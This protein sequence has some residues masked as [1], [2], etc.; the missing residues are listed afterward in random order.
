MGGVLISTPPHGVQ[1]R[2]M[3]IISNVHISE[4]WLTHIVSG[5]KTHE[6]RVFRGHWASLKVGDIL[7]AHS[8]K[9]SRVEL[10][11][12]ELL[13]FE[14][15]DSAFSQLGKFLL[16]EGAETPE[17]CLA[18]YRQ[19]NSAEVVKEAGGVVA[20]GVQVKSVVLVPE[21]EPEP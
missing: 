10:Q 4:P 13:R 19:W 16:P 17:E 2:H 12:T 3:A 15:F 20:V 1:R 6:G 21:C 18:I 14:D 9:Y 8:D 7:E 5:A 11:V